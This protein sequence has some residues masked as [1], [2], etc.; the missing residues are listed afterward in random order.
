MPRPPPPPAALTNKES[1][2]LGELARQFVRMHLA[3]R[4]QWNPGL[5]RHG[6]RRQLVTGRGQLL[7][8]GSDEDETVLFAQACER[9][10]LGEKP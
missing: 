5:L 2:S 4:S 8:G 7:R 6:A 3:S 9:G 10:T 1:H